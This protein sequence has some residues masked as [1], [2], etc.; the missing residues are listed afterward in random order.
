MK[1]FM[2]LAAF[3]LPLF[4]GT[5]QGE[6]YRYTD[7]TGSLHFVDD[8]SKVP[9][10]YRKQLGQTGS[11]GDISI[12]D[13]GPASSPRKAEEP[14]PRKGISYGGNT[15]ELY[16]TSW[17]GYCKKM[18]RF[19][20]EKGISY[21]AYDIEQDS[22]AAKTFRELGGRGVPLVRIGSTVIRGYNPDAVLSCL[23]R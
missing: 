9:A 18:E 23:G 13:A 7:S 14:L 19:L 5:A 2:L 16:R 1:Y 17:C 12:V 4:A 22:T 10:K 6:I 15:V 3:I 11:S 21:V 20:K 8:I